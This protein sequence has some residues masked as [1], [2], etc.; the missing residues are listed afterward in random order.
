MVVTKWLCH[1]EL[2]S[3]LLC[4]AVPVNAPAGH[5]CVD[6]TC[7]TL[8]PALSSVA[9]SYLWHFSFQHNSSSFYTSLLE[10]RCFILASY[11]CTLTCSSLSLTLMKYRLPCQCLSSQTT[12]PPTLSVFFF[13]CLGQ[14]QSLVLGNTPLLPLLHGIGPT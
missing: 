10:C 2:V 1:R 4:T 13:L 14:G 3:S 5:I 9:S 11:M 8:I 12:P 6:G 7:I